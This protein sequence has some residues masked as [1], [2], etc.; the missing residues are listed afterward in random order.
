MKFACL[1]IPCEP[2]C[3]NPRQTDHHGGLF[4]YTAKETHLQT[5]KSSSQASR[6]DGVDKLIQ[7]IHLV[8]GLIT[9]AWFSWNTN[10]MISSCGG[11]V[12]EEG[13]KA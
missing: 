9:E 7:S 3:L 13:G 5:N 12:G 11:F 6:G 10:G 8:P 2:F 1:Q 4:A